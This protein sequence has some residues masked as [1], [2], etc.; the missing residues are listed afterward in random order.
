[1]KLTKEEYKKMKDRA[2]LNFGKADYKLFF[3][4][5]RI[6]IIGEHIDYNGG[7]VLPCAIEIGTYALVKPAKR[8]VI[9]LRSWNAQYYKEVLIGSEFNP[10]NKWVNYTLGMINAISEEGYKVGGLEGVI[11]GNIPTGA[12]LSSSAS[13]EI[14]IGKI[15]NDLYNNSEISMKDLAVLGMKTEN[16]FIGLNSGIMDQFAIAMGSKG[17]AVLLNTGTLDYEYVDA[18][19]ADTLLV[20]LNTNKGRR[21]VDS[22]YNERRA[23]CESALTK[24]QNTFEIKNLCDLTED[25]LEDALA[26]LDLENERRRV[27]HAVTENARVNKA[28]EAIKNAN[29]EELGNLLN[30]SHY[31]LRYDYEVTGDHLDAITSAARKAGALGARMTGAGFGGCGIA[32]VKKDQLDEFKEITG[33]L[34]KEETGLDAEFYETV[35]GS[36]PCELEV[37][38]WEY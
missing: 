20:I 6:N 12:G 27:R 34:Y 28:V 17:K 33:R 36:G 8:D 16:D 24:L 11:Y 30:E 13:L 31:S 15:V 25:K 22:K 14:L 2:I 5:S 32:L 21:L 10:D 38:N 37:E 1:M 29:M 7:N 4:P 35:I 9:R 19:L 26:L 23:E 3:S 18:D